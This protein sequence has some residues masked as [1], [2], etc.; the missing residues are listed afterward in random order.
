[1]GMALSSRI[2][3][4][5]TDIQCQRNVILNCVVIVVRRFRSE[6]L[7]PASG[8]AKWLGPT[9][10]WH[11]LYK[12]SYVAAG[13]GHV[14]CSN[15]CPR[16][17]N[18]FTLCYYTSCC[19]VLNLVPV[20]ENSGPKRVLAKRPGPQLGFEL[21][22]TWGPAKWPGPRSSSWVSKDKEE[23]IDMLFVST[24]WHLFVNAS[25]L[26]IKTIGP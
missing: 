22:S 19:V 11:W 14:E 15:C 25:V 20:R 21:L 3:N 24:Y 17:A 6:C 13:A 16:H 18:M 9:L 4:L 8:P 23:K 26:V 1:M 10:I 2:N 7:G 5:N 12:S